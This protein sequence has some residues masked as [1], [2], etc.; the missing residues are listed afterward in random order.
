M[1]GLQTEQVRSGLRLVLG[2]FGTFCHF[3]LGALTAPMEFYKH[4]PPKLK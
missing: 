3:I 4:T 2:P 1:I